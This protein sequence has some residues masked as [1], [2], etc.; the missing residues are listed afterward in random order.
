MG[1]PAR[2][3]VRARVGALPRLLPPTRRAESPHKPER[4]H[5]ALLASHLLLRLP[6]NPHPHHAPAHLASHLGHP[7]AHHPRCHQALL[8]LLW[9]EL[10]L[11]HPHL[12]WLEVVLLL[13]PHLLLHLR[14][15][16]VLGLG[17]GGLSANPKWGKG[18]GARR[19]SWRR[20]AAAVPG[21]A[22]G[23]GLQSPAS[24]ILTHSG[25]V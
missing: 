1:V 23:A 7:A 24:S 15:H 16:G 5:P 4:A 18:S 3:C 12:L 2:A 25:E 21:R 17:G 14:L 20:Q 22:A 10:L 8:L 11:L 19:P 13:H 6:P 9:L